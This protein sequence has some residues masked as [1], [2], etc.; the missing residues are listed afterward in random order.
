MFMTPVVEF[1]SW[2][3]VETTCGTFVIPADLAE[4]TLS[5]VRE[6]VEGTPES[7]ETREGWG[8][9]LSAPGYLDATDWTLFQSEAEA[10]DHLVEVFDV[11][12][13]CHADEAAPDSTD[14]RCETC[15]DEPV[16]A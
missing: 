16:D 15:A 4:G 7:V 8:A 3:V 10:L 11:C 1:G 2:H 5:G 13:V 12:P 6:Y 9:R 14:G